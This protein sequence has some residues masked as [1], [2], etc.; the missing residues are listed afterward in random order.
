MHPDRRLFLSAAALS[1]L[2]RN[3]H[4]GG[5]GRLSLWAGDE[6]AHGHRDGA[7]LQAL[8]FDPRGLARDPRDGAIVVAD[9]ANALIRRIGADGVVHT[10][11]GAAEQRRSVDGPAAQ[12]RFVGPD[13]VAVGPDGVVYIADAFANTIRELRDGVVRTLAGR[14]GE[15]GFADGIGVRAQFNHPIGV[16][17]LGDEL[18]VADAYNNTLRAIDRAGRV[19]TVAGTPGVADHRDGRAAQALFNTP[20]GLAVAGD[21]ALYVSEYFNHDLRVLAPDGRVSTLAGAPGQPGDI[22]GVGSAAR[23]RKPQQ[24]CIEP[25]SGDIIV[26]DGGNHKVRRIDRAGR[27]R[28]LAGQGAREDRL[29]LGALPGALVTPYGVAPGPGASVLVSAGEAL[30]RIDP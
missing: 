20:V 18:W 17:L 30:L 29:L 10:V 16:A 28:T 1:L 7:R 22:D 6:H 8:F 24:I 25:V 11:A 12:A 2:A 26:A 27:V 19:R 9:A 14:A 21:G 13:A 4:A 5:R 3:A 23:L 15:P